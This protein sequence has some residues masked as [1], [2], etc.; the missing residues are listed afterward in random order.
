MRELPKAVGKTR[1][2]SGE[3]AVAVH[4]CRTGGSRP[5]ARLAPSPHRTRTARGRWLGPSASTSS[6]VTDRDGVLQCDHVPPA[7]ERSSPAASDPHRTGIEPLGEEDPPRRQTAHRIRRLLDQ[8]AIRSASDRPRRPRRAAQQPPNRATSRLLRGSG[9]ALPPPP[10]THPTARHSIPHRRRRDL[11]DDQVEVELGDQLGIDGIQRASIDKRRPDGGV[12][13][14]ARQARRVDPRCSHDR[15]PDDLRR[16][17]ALLGDTDDR[18]DQAEL[19]DDLGRAG[20]QRASA[21]SSSTRPR[22]LPRQ[23]LL[24]GSWRLRSQIT[25]I[26]RREELAGVR[27]ANARR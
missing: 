21:R 4:R 19:G 9:E 25:L 3:M 10:D 14:R 27:L 6:Q 15:L 23:R 2:G 16:P 22:A 1:A 24:T 8:R 5:T 13:L 12:D 18:V 20:E 7:R 11:G 26:R 17:S